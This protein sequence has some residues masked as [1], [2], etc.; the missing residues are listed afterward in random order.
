MSSVSNIHRLCRCYEDPAPERG[1]LG[2]FLPPSFQAM[3][4]FVRLEHESRRRASEDEIVLTQPSAPGIRSAKLATQSIGS[5][6]KRD[7]YLPTHNGTQLDL[8]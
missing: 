4:I 3:L 2:P 6:G 5:R 7:F 1:E 8:I